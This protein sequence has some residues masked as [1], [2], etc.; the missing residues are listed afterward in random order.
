MVV[1]KYTSIKKVCG[2]RVYKAGEND[3]CNT[4]TKK[5]N[6]TKKY[7]KAEY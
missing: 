5:K 4:E 6:Q 3:T 2:R 7:G 1:R